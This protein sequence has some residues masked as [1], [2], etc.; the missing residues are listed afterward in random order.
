MHCKYHFVFE[1]VHIIGQV[2]CCIDSYVNQTRPERKKADSLLVYSNFAHEGS[3]SQLLR[4]LTS[5]QGQA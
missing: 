2:T 1:A 3:V 4:L 5:Y